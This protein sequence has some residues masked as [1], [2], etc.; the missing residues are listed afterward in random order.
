MSN[1]SLLPSEEVEVVIG[2]ERYKRECSE[3]EDERGRR[4][5]HSGQGE[6]GRGMGEEQEGH[7]RVGAEAFEDEDEASGLWDASQLLGVVQKRRE[8]VDCRL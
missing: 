4:V 5:E 6:M 7:G 3:S 1:S 8:R 2:S